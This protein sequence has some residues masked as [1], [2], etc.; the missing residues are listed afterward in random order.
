MT[1]NTKCQHT[2][3][4]PIGWDYCYTGPVS[5]G[6]YNPAAHGCITRT[7]ECRACGA[8]RSVNINQRFRERGCWGP[9]R[10]ERD[11][12]ARRMERRAREMSRPAVARVTC[13]DGRAVQV[14]L[15]EEGLILVTGARHSEDEA[16]AIVAALPEPWIARAQAVRRA[17]IAAQVARAEV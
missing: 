1:R 7:E 8:R 16:T 3:S 13:A 11:E 15:D 5:G 17:I 12:E 6:E 14:S 2:E 4:R 9:S 10:A